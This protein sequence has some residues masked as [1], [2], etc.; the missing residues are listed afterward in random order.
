MVSIPETPRLLLNFSVSFSRLDLLYKNPSSTI[1]PSSLEL[2]SAFEFRYESHSP[3][4]LFCIA[5][6]NARLWD[7]FG[8]GV[9]LLAILAASCKGPGIGKDPHGLD[10]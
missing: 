10:S 5:V 1:P 4:L 8:F 3:F 2:N 6:L 7:L 9:G